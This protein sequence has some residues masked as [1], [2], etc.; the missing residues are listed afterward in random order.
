MERKG[1]PDK[2]SKEV[3]GE[4]KGI[5]YTS[6]VVSVSRYNYVLCLHAPMCVTVTAELREPD[7]VLP[8]NLQ[9]WS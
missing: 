6:I 2:G 5:Q 3:D 1:V 9:H 8:S 4:R 7:K